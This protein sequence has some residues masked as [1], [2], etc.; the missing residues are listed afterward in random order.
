MR[1]G[2]G[3]LGSCAPERPL[4]EHPAA[5][6]ADGS[7]ELVRDACAADDQ[8]RAYGTVPVGKPHL[9]EVDVHLY[10]A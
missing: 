10:G 8:A 9:R 7:L 2:F 3:Y 5:V 6:A 4:G 1:R